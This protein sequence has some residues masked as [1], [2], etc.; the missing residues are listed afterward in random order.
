[1]K[2][3]KTFKVGDKIIHFD[4]VYRIFKIRGG[5]NKDKV[6]FFRRYFKGK[7]NR[8]LIFSIPISSIDETKVRRPLS[9][10]KLKDLF[11]ILGQ[12]SKVKIVISTV[13]TKEEFE[14]N[15]PHKNVEILN[16]LWQEKESDP[17]RFNKSKES[18][19]KLAIEKLSEEIAFVFGV[20]LVKAKK[21]IKNALEKNK[22]AG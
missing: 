3:D 15:N 14:S 8:V 1:M 11:K 20:S 13:K 16:R 22:N 4:Q 2:K 12:K 5:K 6:I 17:E 19:F 10:K 21:K 18:L 7:E 9:K